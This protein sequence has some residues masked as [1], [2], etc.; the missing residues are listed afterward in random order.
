MIR[1]DDVSPSRKL[2]SAA[3]TLFLVGLLT[4]VFRVLAQEQPTPSKA[5]SNRS[6]PSPAAGASSQPIAFSHRIHAGTNAIPCQLC[7]T[8]ARRGPV[9]GIPSVQRC[10]QCHQTVTPEEPEVVKLM[11]YW[12]DKKPIAWVRVHDLPDFVRFTH[13]PHVA[14]GVACQTCHGDVA[15]MEGAVQ[16]ESLSMGWCLNCHKERHAPTDC[17]VCHY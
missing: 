8:Y 7:H 13:K 3:L 14:A 12:K 9:A 17:L 4:F 10:V 6:A 11:A 16:T 1:R 5:A 2:S 15:K